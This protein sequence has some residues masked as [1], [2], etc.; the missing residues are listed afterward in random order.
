[1]SDRGG[2]GLTRDIILRI[3]AKN[4]STADFRAACDVEDVED[5]ARAI[6][7]CA[8]NGFWRKPGCASGRPDQQVGQARDVEHRPHLR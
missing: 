6:E 3:S 5:R 4:V 8:V 2:G 1:M 7:S